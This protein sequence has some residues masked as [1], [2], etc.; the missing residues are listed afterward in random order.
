MAAGRNGGY[1]NY[2]R[3]R[4]SGEYSTAYAHLSRFAKG[5]RR[6]PAGPSGPGDRLCRHDRPRDRAAPAL[7][8]AAQRQADQSADVKQPPNTQLAGADLERFHQEVGRI[9]RL[10]AELAGDT[11][12]ASKAGAASPAANDPLARPRAEPAARPAPSLGGQAARRR[13]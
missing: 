11:Q 1:G 6:R 2:I 4:H 5:I 9:D 3:I 10:R 12:V 7:R 13:R 8:G